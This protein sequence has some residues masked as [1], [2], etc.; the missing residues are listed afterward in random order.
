MVNLAL[1]IINSKINRVN[2][3]IKKAIDVKNPDAETMR[4]DVLK[5]VINSDATET[6]RILTL[7][8]SWG[9]TQ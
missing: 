8:R 9:H 7:H 3:Y 2:I 4:Y 5:T 1:I 6:R